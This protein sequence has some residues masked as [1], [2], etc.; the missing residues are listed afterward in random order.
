V[1]KK[2]QKFYLFHVIHF[3]D[4]RH[5]VGKKFMQAQNNSSSGGERERERERRKEK[6]HEKIHQSRY[7]V[8]L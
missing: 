2:F 4:D 3:F 6:K 1:A 8:T 7:E 5:Q